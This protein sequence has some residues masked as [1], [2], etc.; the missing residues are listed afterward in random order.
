V[1]LR[2]RIDNGP[3]QNIGIGYKAMVRQGDL[4]YPV[5]QFDNVP[6]SAARQGRTITFSVN[7]DGKPV[8]PEYYEYSAPP[9]LSSPS[10][11]SPPALPP[12]A[13]PPSASCQ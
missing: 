5:W 6:V 9:P 11:D 12:S 1:T 4:T 2:A 13:P 8:I 10:P 3:D 7:V